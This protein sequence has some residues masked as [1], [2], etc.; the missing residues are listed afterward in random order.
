MGIITNTC[1]RTVN[2]QET[3]EPG[4]S[5][6]L[7]AAFRPPRVGCPGSTFRL[8]VVLRQPRAR[9]PSCRV[10]PTS[11]GMSRKPVFT[12]AVV[13]P[14]RAGY[15][16][17]QGGRASCPER[18]V[19]PVRDTAPHR[20]DGLH[21]PGVS[22]AP[23]PF[24]IRCVRGFHALSALCGVFIPHRA[25]EPPEKD[26]SSAPCP[27]TE[28]TNREYP[29]QSHRKPRTRRTKRQ[30][31]RTRR[32]KRQGP[33]RSGRKHGV[34]IGLGALFHPRIISCGK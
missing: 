5:L 30:G 23:C 9:C 14:P 1:V 15:G 22:S 34:A 19:R 12:R 25:D 13:R 2:S 29:A 11:C 10:S 26:V 7:H 31:P 6:Y 16:A 27:R 4:R 18:F 20:A 17:A 21:A 28:R 24:F 33:A 3:Q 8:R 32:T